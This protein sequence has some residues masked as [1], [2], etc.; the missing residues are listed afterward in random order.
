MMNEAPDVN[1]RNIALLTTIA[2][3]KAIT[4][5]NATTDEN[6]TINAMLDLYITKRA[7][8]LASFAANTLPGSPFA[9]KLRAVQAALGIKV[10]GMFGVDSIMGIVRST[11]DPSFDDILDMLTD[12]SGTVTPAETAAELGA[13]I[14]QG[15]KGNKPGTDLG[16]FLVG[17]TGTGTTGVK[18]GPGPKVG[19]PE[20]RR[21]LQSIV[22][23]LSPNV[24]AT[25]RKNAVA[26]ERSGQ[27]STSYIQREMAGNG[28]ARAAMSVNVLM[29]YLDIKP[30]PEGSLTPLSVADLEAMKADVLN[31]SGALTGGIVGT[32]GTGSTGVKTNPVPVRERFGRKY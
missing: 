13:L 21:V 15:N 7:P 29:D 28:V 30:G 1:S 5:A 23:M 25:I 20:P 16:P 12:D 19:L 6:M 32:T 26:M 14:D 8:K 9:R 11:K 31:S 24:L 22:R 3:G 27:D 2:N 17:A 4:D 18:V 10:D